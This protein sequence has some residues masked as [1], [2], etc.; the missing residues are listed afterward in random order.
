MKKLT[1]LHRV[2]SKKLCKLIF[3]SEPCQISTGRENLWHKDSKE[4]KL[5]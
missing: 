1:F 3:L 5:F 4:D 2:D